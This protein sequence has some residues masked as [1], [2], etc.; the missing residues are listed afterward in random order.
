M[1]TKDDW[2][3][4]HNKRKRMMSKKHKMEEIHSNAHDCNK[5]KWVQLTYK[6]E[7]LSN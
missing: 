5:Y 1:D 6:R 3:E 4:I 2:K 7:I